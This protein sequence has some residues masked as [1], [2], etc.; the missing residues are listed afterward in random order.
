MLASTSEPFPLLSGVP[1]GLILGRILFL[2]YVKNLPKSVSQ[3]LTILN[4]IR[5]FKIF[6]TAKPL[7]TSKGDVTTGE[8]S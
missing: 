5:L 2:I 3:G 1:K 7:I 4:V 8:W 6:K